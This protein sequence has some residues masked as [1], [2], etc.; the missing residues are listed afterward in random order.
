MK[1]WIYVKQNLKLLKGKVMDVHF[2]VTV[3]C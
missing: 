2:P 1:N 3:N